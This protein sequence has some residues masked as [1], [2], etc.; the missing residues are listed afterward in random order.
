MANTRTLVWFRD[1]LRVADNPALFHAR[2]QGDVVGVFLVADQQWLAHHVGESRRAFLDATLAALSKAMAELNIPLIVETA[3]RFADAPE[4]LVR[5]AQ[6]LSAQALTFNEQFPLNERVRD[7][8]V[9]RACEAAGIRVQQFQSG[10]LMPVGSVLTQN[11]TPYTVF[12]AFKRRWLATI[13]PSAWTPLPA[14]AAQRPLTLEIPSGSQPPERE[15]DNSKDAGE[16]AAEQRLQHFLDGHIQRYDELRDRPAVDGT[17]R[18]SAHLSV[19]SISARQCLTAAMLAGSPSA[20]TR[21]RPAGND[22]GIDS[23]I[24]EL[25]WRDFYRHI[26]ALFPHIS[27]GEAFR[28]E[29]DNIPWRTAEADLAAWKAGQTG[30]PLVDAAMRQ[31]NATGWMHNRLRMVSAMFLS[32][33]LLLDWRLGERYFMKQ[34]TDGDFAANNGG[35]QWSS[36]TGTDA[37]PYFRIF[38]PAT[39]GERFDPDASFVKQYLPELAHLSA[40][41]IFREPSSKAPDYPEPIVE[42]RFARERALTTFKRLRG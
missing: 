12:S 10:T 31:L 40:K 21:P 1:D 6:A 25:I 5:L 30:Y 19:G 22:P 23:W 34:L 8:K 38:N 2:E 35:W 42:H 9:L 17:S 39:Q 14:P 32:K 3:P 18:L 27:R 37:A 41:Q 15:P 7:S 20:Q 4:I 33:H 13:E 24:N 29:T 11:A 28:R 16:A 36:S 26:I